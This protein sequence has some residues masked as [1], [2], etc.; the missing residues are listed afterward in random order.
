M[1]MVK[2]PGKGIAPRVAEKEG[3]EDT[4]SGRRGEDEAMSDVLYH[5]RLAH[6][7]RVQ[8]SRR[9]VGRRLKHSD[10]CLGADGRAPMCTRRHACATPLRIFL[11]ADRAEK[12]RVIHVFWIVCSHS[13][14][15][16]KDF[17]AL[18]RAGHTAEADVRLATTPRLACIPSALP[19][20]HRQVMHAYLLACRLPRLPCCSGRMQL[21]VQ[22]SASLIHYSSP[23]AVAGQCTSV[24]RRRRCCRR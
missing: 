14:N 13:T 20:Q 5:L 9:V 4:A 17:R 7:W 23:L 12:R 6:E 24:R 8:G 19:G 18:M 16:P 22:P 1:R 2:V 15:L 10:R 11:H 21:R 3:S